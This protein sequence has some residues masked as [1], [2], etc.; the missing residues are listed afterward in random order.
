MQ[1]FHNAAPGA[2]ALRVKGEDKPAIIPGGESLTA[3]F[4]PLDDETLTAL[5]AEGC[6]FKAPPKPKKAKAED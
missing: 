4:E 6:T 5:K 1:T 3:D 2:K